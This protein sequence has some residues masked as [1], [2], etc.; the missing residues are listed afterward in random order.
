MQKQNKYDRKHIQN[1]HRIEQQVEA[2]Y[3]TAADEAV[4]IA[5]LIGADFNPE[6]LFSFQDYPLTRKRVETLL[7]TLRNGIETA[8]VNGVRS[9]WTLANN[10][11][12]ELCRVVFGDALSHLTQ[13]QQRRYFSTNPK[14]QEAFIQRKVAGLRLSDR[15]WNYSNLFKREIELGLDLGIRGGLS[16]DEMSRQLRQ[17]LRYPDKLFRRVKDEHG[18]LV[19][20]KAA[21]AFHPGKGVYRSS[22][23]NAR[24]LAATE[25]NI[26]YR[27]A[28]HLRWQELDFVVGIEIHVSQT[29]HPVPDICDDLKGKYPKDFKF[30]GWHPHCR[31]YATSVLKTKEEIMEDNRRILAGEP[32]T[33][34]SVNT[35]TDVPKGFN[36]WIADNRERA[37]G[38]E[39][40][41]Y[42][43]RDNPQYVENFRVDTYSAAERTFTRHYHTSPAMK[44]SMAEYLHKLYPQLETTEMAAIYDYTRGDVSDFRHLNLHLRKGK[45]SEFEQALSELL[46]QGLS[47]LPTTTETVY[48]TIR[49]NKTNLNAWLE[50]AQKQGTQTWEAFTSTSIS[51]DSVEEIIKHKAKTLQNNERDVLLV[52]KGKSGHL[53]E[54]L[55]MFNGQNGFPNQH[56]V[57]F[58]RGLKV[59]FDGVTNINGRITFNLTE[60]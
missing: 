11:N 59:R 19:L 43:V 13:A 50:T 2:V 10:K 44:A 15:V 38:W 41:P 55:S 37:K 52:I 48:R 32:L 31:C 49:L 60:I 30:T 29:N 36:D 4:K 7:E 12:N 3:M 1:L 46:S 5:E 6:T 20:S 22:Y 57:L 18:D 28:D 25:C 47:K 42:F 54:D 33:D 56:E 40:M 39:T 35:V 26:A 17:Y 21:A 23:K 16:A 51:I 53:I 45:L 27:T 34:D 58:D 8:I 9:E 24:R 14:A